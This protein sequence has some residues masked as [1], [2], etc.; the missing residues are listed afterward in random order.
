MS[1]CDNFNLGV[2]KAGR[3]GR[4]FCGGGNS[5]QG[6]SKNVKRR[7]RGQFFKSHRLKSSKSKLLKIVT[8]GNK[9]IRF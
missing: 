4:F 8:L 7:R 2:L 5:G 1:L 3:V 9:I 6:L